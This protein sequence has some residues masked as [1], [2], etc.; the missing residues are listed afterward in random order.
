MNS[1][2]NELTTDIKCAKP[3]CKK[4]KIQHRSL[5]LIDDA[6]PIIIINF[7]RYIYDELQDEYKKNSQRINF[8]YQN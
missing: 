2:A 1:Y 5:Q 7:A 3:G 8:E 4:T 6:P